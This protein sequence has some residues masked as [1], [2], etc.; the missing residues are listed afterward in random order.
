MVIALLLVRV[1]LAAVF[2]VAGFAKQGIKVLDILFQ[3]RWRSCDFDSFGHLLLCLLCPQS[4]TLFPPSTNYRYITRGNNTLANCPQDI[5]Y[6][7]VWDIVAFIIL[8]TAFLFCFLLLGILF[9]VIG[10]RHL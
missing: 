4:I 8:A 5:P 1:I 3:R 9:I 2:F 10:F 7:V 6:E